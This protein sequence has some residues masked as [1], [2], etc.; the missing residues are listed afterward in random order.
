[1]TEFEQFLLPS[2]RHSPTANMQSLH[3]EQVAEQTCERWGEKEKNVAEPSHAYY[4]CHRLKLYLC[5]SSE[6]DLRLSSAA[7][8]ESGYVTAAERRMQISLAESKGFKAFL[9]FL[10]SAQV[11]YTLVNITHMHN[12]F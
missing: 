3:Q 5:T 11:I 1:M 12:S 7:L 4:L 9:Q 8:A 2:S 10:N 6:L